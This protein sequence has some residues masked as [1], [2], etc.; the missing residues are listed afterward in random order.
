MKLFVITL[1]ATAFLS[2]QGSAK[3]GGYTLKGGVDHR[4]M[5]DKPAGYYRSA[6][7]A[8]MYIYEAMIY[9]TKDHYISYINIWNF[10]AILLKYI[11][12]TIRP[13]T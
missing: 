3:P 11:L 12:R 10:N 4:M 2:V 13:T 6:Q 1:F 7:S 8:G 9:F 5:H